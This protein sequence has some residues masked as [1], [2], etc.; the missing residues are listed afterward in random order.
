MA[1]T[2]IPPWYTSPV[3]ERADVILS[4]FLWG[5]TMCLAI[6]AGAK[7]YRQ[8]Y[9]SWKRRRSFTL[10]IV[11]IWLELV[12]GVIVAVVCWFYI[13]DWIQPSFWFFFGM[14]IMWAIE[15]QCLT[16]ILAN[17]ISLVLYDHEKARK[18]KLGVAIAI[19]LINISVFIV[20]IPA[21][22]QISEKWIFANNIWDRAEKCIFLV[23]DL[24]LNAYF[25]WLIKIK[26]I[27]NGLTRYRLV[28]RFNLGMVCLSITIDAAIIGIMSL[29]DDT[30]YIQAH[31]MA[32]IMKL[33]IEM[34]LAELIAKVIK[35]SNQQRNNSYEN[36]NSYYYNNNDIEQQPEPEPNNDQTDENY[37]RE[38][39]RTITKVLKPTVGGGGQMHDLDTS[40]LDDDDD[41]DDYHPDVSQAAASVTCPERAHIRKES[42]GSSSLDPLENQSS[43]C[44]CH[45]TSSRDYATTTV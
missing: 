13:E 5:F 30:V 3:L 43:T 10:Y 45:G 27:A 29:R 12:T 33:Y 14:L 39:R 2:L 1:G 7:A 9:R 23:I 6:F 4:S 34:N 22:L 19:G 8:T 20:W 36:D 38:W 32:Y 42:G 44:T 37:T 21:R 35:K 41:D 25:M 11:M 24:S 17:R 15:I 28:Y 16:Q 18:I 31:A 40:V 26:L